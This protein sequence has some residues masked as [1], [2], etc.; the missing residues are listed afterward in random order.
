VRLLAVACAALVV[1]PAADAAPLVVR[2]SLDPGTVLFGAPATATVTVVAD[3][4]LVDPDTIRIEADVAPFRRLGLSVARDG[5][6]VVRRTRIACVSDACRP[7]DGLRPVRLPPVQVTAGGPGGP[8]AVSAD[9]PPLLVAPRVPSDAAAG[10]PEWRVD[11]RPP[12]LTTRVDPGTLSRWLWV[13]AA[14]LALGAAALV[15]REVLR[16]RTRTREERTT[17]LAAAL[18]AVRASAQA[19]EPERRRAVGAL[20][21]VLERVDGD[22]AVAAETLAWSEPGPEPERVLALADEVEREVRA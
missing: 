10:E 9:W 22:H 6:L 4:A 20:A 5:R 16:A 14:A 21:K 1:L 7:G 8:V 17:E 19:P 13:L 11:A 15:A 12:P 3:P 18:A 2:T